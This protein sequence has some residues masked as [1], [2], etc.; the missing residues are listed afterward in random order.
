MTANLENTIVQTDVN[1]I[2]VNLPQLSSVFPG[3]DINFTANVAGVITVT[4][5]SGDT[6]GGLATY[7]V[8]ALNGLYLTVLADTVNGD[9]KIINIS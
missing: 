1:T 7:T 8:N 4:P 2:V 6:I 9:W 5:Y 3:D